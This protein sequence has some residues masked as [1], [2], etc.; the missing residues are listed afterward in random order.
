MFRVN[1]VSGIAA[2]LV[3]DGGNY[4][5]EA[6]SGTDVTSVSK[7]RLIV[8]SNGTV[9]IND[10]T[11]MS[12]VGGKTNTCVYQYDAT[13]TLTINGGKFSPAPI[14]KEGANSVIKEGYVI[15]DSNADGWY[16]LELVDTPAATG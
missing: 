11:F 16:E 12:N 3:I 7:N 15:A 1:T 10:G 13:G 14:V 8:Y 2:E 9:T 4:I 5:F 6:T